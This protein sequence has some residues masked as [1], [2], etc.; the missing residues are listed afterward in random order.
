MMGFSMVR[1]AD[2]ITAEFDWRSRV[3]DSLSL[4]ALILEPNRI[5]LDAN[6]AFLK[7]FDITKDEIIGQTCHEFLLPV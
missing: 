6:K 7:K 4:P 5:V 2:E 3:F 1:G